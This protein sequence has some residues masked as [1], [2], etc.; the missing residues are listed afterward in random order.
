VAKL[1]KRIIYHPPKCPYILAVDKG[2]N[3]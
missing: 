2:G 1:L 3:N